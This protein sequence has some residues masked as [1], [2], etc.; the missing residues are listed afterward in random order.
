M[1]N[2][3]DWLKCNLVH[4]TEKLRKLIIENPDCPLLIFAGEE[5][6]CGDYSYM[7]CT[8]V[9]VKKDCVLIL[10]NESPAPPNDE[11][12]Y[13]GEDELEDDIADAVYND[14]PDA[15]ESELDAEVKKRMK[16]FEPY[17]KDCIVVYAT[18]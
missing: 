2:M 1:R 15:S 9:S 11:L 10:D 17:W 18:N 13:I 12:V 14:L 16:E 3:K 4:E 8:D 7:A 5:A 6:N